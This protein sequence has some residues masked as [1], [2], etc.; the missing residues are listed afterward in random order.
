M[1]RKAR[2]IEYT[3]NK[4]ANDLTPADYW[5][6]RV[7]VVDALCCLSVLEKLMDFTIQIR[8]QL[9]LIQ[10]QRVH[11]LVGEL[12]IQARWLRKVTDHFKNINAVWEQL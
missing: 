9:Q 1:H 6:I 12:F 5:D 3:V 11:A 2:G 10:V 7:F 8:P 4:P